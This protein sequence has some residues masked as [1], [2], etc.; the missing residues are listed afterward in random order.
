M[1]K[2]IVMDMDGTLLN[3]DNKISERTRKALALAQEQGA[4]LV[5][6][7]GRSY[8]RM[9]PYA[10]E[11]QM[12]TKGGHLIE[13]DGVAFYNTKTGER[14]KL[15]MMQPEEVQDIMAWLMTQDA[16]T[17]GMFDDGGFIWFPISHLP[18]KQKIREEQHLPEDYPWTAGP[19]SYLTD[20]RDGYP[21]ITYIRR[22]EDINRPINKFQIMNEEQRLEPVYQG[23]MDHFSDHFS[24]YRTTPRQLEV[25]PHGYS[26]GSGVR[27]LMEQNGWTPD[28]VLVFGDGENDVSMFPE[29]THS[30][31]MGN[32]RDYVKDRAAHVTGTNN[33]DGIA[34]ALASYFDLSAL[35]DQSKEAR[36]TASAAAEDAPKPAHA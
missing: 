7:S 36:S 2:A 1:I 11:L 31:A 10:R 27:H 30:Y 29:V 21:N 17:Q 13:V 22:P 12:D 14:E 23:L 33:E 5:L 8:T 9:L 19:W 20:F 16:E 4:E 35:D 28:E 26:K 25:L 32:A 18:I 6:A 15:R 24:I 3:K 34:Q